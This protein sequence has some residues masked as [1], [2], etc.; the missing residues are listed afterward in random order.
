MKARNVRADATNLIP[1]HVDVISMG[2][3]THDRRL[4]R[5][6]EELGIDREF[7][8]FTD[9]LRRHTE[10]SPLEVEDVTKEGAVLFTDE[11]VAAWKLASLH[12]AFH[13][14]AVDASEGILFI[15]VPNDPKESD[16]VL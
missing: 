15:E 6:E 1:P 4:R 7:E 16:P 8:D 13:N 9:R 3:N 2:N 10:D 12:A 11:P 14:V 5:I